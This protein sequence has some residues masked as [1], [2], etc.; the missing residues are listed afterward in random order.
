MIE[1]FDLQSQS[2]R[3]AFDALTEAA[4]QCKP[5]RAPLPG[6]RGWAAE[7][8]ARRRQQ[9]ERETRVSAELEQAQADWRDAYARHENA[10]VRAVLDIHQPEAGYDHA[11]CTDCRESDCGEAAAIEWQC[12]TFTA[13]NDTP[14]GK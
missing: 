4:R 10:A 8:S 7:E 12:A 13:I 5:L 2:T 9:R 1:P 11:V 14:E 6:M 3:G